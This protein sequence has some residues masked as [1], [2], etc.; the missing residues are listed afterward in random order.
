M[1]PTCCAGTRGFEQSIRDGGFAA[2]SDG[3]FAA[4]FSNI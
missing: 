1:A 3:G 4:S 2:G